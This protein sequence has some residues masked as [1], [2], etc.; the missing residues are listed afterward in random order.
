MLTLPGSLGVCTGA[1]RAGEPAWLAAGVGL[2]VVALLPTKWT[3]V[4]WPLQVGGTALVLAQAPVVRS[5]LGG[6]GLLLV[7]AGAA[8]NLLVWVQARFA[9]GAAGE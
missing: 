4:T 8:V 6:V 9:V 3:P 1:W 2:L 7:L 5:V